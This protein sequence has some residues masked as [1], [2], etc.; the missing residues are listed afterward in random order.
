MKT[1]WSPLDPVEFLFNRLFGGKHFAEEAG[2]TMEDSVL[3]RIGYNTIAV[4]GLSQQAC[5]EWR[6]LTRVQQDWTTFKIHFT[7]ADKDRVNYKTLQDG[8]YHTAN[9]TTMDTGI[10]NISALTETICL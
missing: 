5:Y 7:A 3:T 9:N 6:K 1:A 2:D 4:N 8:G 10:S